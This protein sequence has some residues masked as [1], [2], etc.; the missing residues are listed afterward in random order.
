MRL[1]PD[2]MLIFVTLSSARFLTLSSFTLFLYLV[3]LM[4]CKWALVCLSLLS[5][6]YVSPGIQ[7]HY[8]MIPKHWAGQ[9]M[10][11]QPQRLVYMTRITSIMSTSLVLLL[12][13][14]LLLFC[15]ALM[16]LSI[17]FQSYHDGVWLRQ[18][19]QC[20]LL[21]CRVTD[22]SCPRH[23]TLYYTQSHYPNTASTNPSS[24]PRLS[25]KAGAA[26]TVFKDFGMSR[27]GIEPVT[28]FRGADTL[29]T[30]L[31]GQ[32]HPLCAHGNTVHACAS[33]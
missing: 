24:T 14:L 9:N 4:Q 16:S 33:S 31:P 12:L 22:V 29:P 17:I 7:T 20:S 32:V 26:S 25:A 10:W 3:H 21:L 6:I 8:F 5:G 11:I 27:P 23:L 1:T 19:A 18:E 2:P 15:S 13:L 30:E 28:S